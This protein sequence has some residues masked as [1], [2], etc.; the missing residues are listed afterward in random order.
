[1]LTGKKIII[2]GSEGLIGSELSKYLSKNFD[3]LKLD[4]ELGHDLTDES[5]VKEW[6]KNNHA[7]CLVNCFAMNDHVEKNQKR[8]T[9]FDITLESFSKILQVNLVSLFSVCR[10]FAR[11]NDSGSIINFSASTGI[12]SARP[13]LYDGAHKHTAYSVSK[14]GV[15]NLTKFLATHLAPNFRVNCVA[16][17]GVEHN[18]DEEF[19]KKYSKLTP[20]GRMMKKDELNGIIEFLCSDKSSYV[21]GS[22]VVLD[23]G[24]TTW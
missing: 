23:G 16:P 7:D 14:A 13:D 11:N 10:E 17:G 15:I 3:V 19:K 18:Q 21:T 8:G 22:T 20:L 4:L 24:W 2:T 1:M 9:L 12:V 6:F 5:F